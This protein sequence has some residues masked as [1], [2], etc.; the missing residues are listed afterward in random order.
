MNT[1]INNLRQTRQIYLCGLYISTSIR[2]SSGLPIETGHKMLRTLM[3]SYV[4]STRCV[5]GLMMTL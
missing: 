4:M 3:G 1:K 5:E 2:S